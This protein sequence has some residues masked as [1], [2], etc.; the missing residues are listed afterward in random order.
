MNIIRHCLVIFITLSSVY[1]YSQVPDSS[2]NESLQL[3]EKYY[4]KVNNKI[5]A[6]NDKL[7]KKSLKYLAKF[8]RQE[9]KIQ[10]KMQKLNPEKVTNVL[11]KETEKYKEFSQKIKSKTA[12]ATKGISG[13]YNPYLD[14]LGTSLSFLKQFNGISDRVKEPLAGFH[15]LQS[16]LQQSEKIKEFIAERKNQIKELLSKYTKLPGGLRKQYTNLSKTAYYYSA[17]V[18]EYKEML[19]DPKKV[20]R[21][22]LSMLSKLPAFQKFMRQNGQLASLFSLPGNNDPTQ[23]LT[24]LQTRSSVQGLIQQ[25]ISGSGRNAQ[26]QIQSNLAAAHAELDKLKDKLNEFGGGSTDIEMPDFKP[27]AQK[28]KSFLKRLEYS[29]DVQFV[30]SNNLLP[31]AANIGLG[32]GYKLN[33]KGAL[34]TGISYKMGMGSIQHIAFT[35]QGIGL[36]SYMDWKIKKQLYASGGYEMNYNSA[37]KNIQQLK[38]YDAWQRSALIGISKKYKISKKVKGEMKLLYDFLAHQHKPVT[39]EVVYR[40]GYNFK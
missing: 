26:A 3:P 39:P 12:G 10:E 5:N 19:K 20:E 37:F 30:K 7:I 11:S 18:K 22:A 15:E 17:Q 21:K 34:G 1:S 40:L 4:S 36:R 16:K 13:V 27:N 29:A 8:Q 38:N 2:L 14:S 6:V 31:S 9:R 28:T 24:G 35:S 23:S 25:R 33:D 32:V